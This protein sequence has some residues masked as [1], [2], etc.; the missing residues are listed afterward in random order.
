MNGLQIFSPILQAGPFGSLLIIYTTSS[1]TPL[2]PAQPMLLTYLL[3][4]HMLISHSK[5]IIWSFPLAP[6]RFI[7]LLCFLQVHTFSLKSFSFHKFSQ[8]FIWPFNYE[9][10]THGL[11]RKKSVMETLINWLGCFH[12]LW[13]TET[14]TSVHLIPSMCWWLLEINCFY[15]YLIENTSK[16]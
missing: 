5:N 9:L 13:S 7:H 1:P 4:N 11:T 14:I 16:F 3:T 8:K 15:V 2:F 10:M 12:I 6:H